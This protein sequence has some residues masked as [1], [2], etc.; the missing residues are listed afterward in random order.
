MPDVIATDKCW[1]GG[2]LAGGHSASTACCAARR[3]RRFTVAL[4]AAGPPLKVNYP[5]DMARYTGGSKLIILK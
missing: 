2:V 1:V 3:G 5:G 4:R